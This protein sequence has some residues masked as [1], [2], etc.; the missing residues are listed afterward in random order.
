LPFERNF[1]KAQLT[2]YQ[3]KVQHS[4]R[5]F[6]WFV[7]VFRRSNHI[8]VAKKDPELFI[9]NL[10]VRELEEKVLSSMRG[11]WGVNVG[12]PPDLICQLCAE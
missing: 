8:E 2:D 12:E 5:V 7:E 3:F 11:A 9:I 10:K 1:L 4:K 6:S